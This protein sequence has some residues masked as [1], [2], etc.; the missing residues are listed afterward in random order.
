[1]GWQLNQ[2]SS[3]SRLWNQPKT[4]DSVGLA[5]E[6]N[7][8]ATDNDGLASEINGLASDNAGLAT[9]NNGLASEK[10]ELVGN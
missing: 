8:L 10:K 3:S 6:D 7:G 4:D 5:S 9:E 2:A 1:M